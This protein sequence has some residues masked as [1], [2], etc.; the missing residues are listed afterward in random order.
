MCEH[1]RSLYFSPPFSDTHFSLFF[2]SKE[3]KGRNQRTVNKSNDFAH[4]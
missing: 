3:T 1:G 4:A 2:I